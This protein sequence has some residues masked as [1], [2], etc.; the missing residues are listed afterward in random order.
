MKIITVIKTYSDLIKTTP[1]IHTFETYN[2]KNKPTDFE[3]GKD[4][5]PIDYRLVHIG[6]NYDTR[7]SESLRENPVINDSCMCLDVGWGSPAEQ[8]GHTM[9]AFEKVLYKENP[10]WIV[11]T[12]HDNSAL[13]CSLSAKKLNTKICRLEAGLRSKEKNSPDELNRQLTDR[14]GDLLFTQDKLSNENLKAEGI[15]PSDIKFVGNI[16]V[17]SLKL[18]FQRASRTNLPVTLRS[19]LMAAYTHI[20]DK[21]SSFLSSSGGFIDGFCLVS[22][23][24][25]E[26]IDKKD[27]L[28]SLVDFLTGEVSGDMPV[29]WPVHSI[30]QRMLQNFSL[31]EKLLTANNVIL[32]HPL[33]HHE[34]LRLIMSAIITITDSST[35]QEECTTLGTPCLA[36][37]K[38]TERPLTLREY[39]GTTVLTGNQTER[40]KKEYH[41]NRRLN[42]QPGRPDFWDGKTAMRCLDAILERETGL[43]QFSIN[44]K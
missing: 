30:T 37:K 29:I 20:S 17:D 42:Y 15:A 27:R 4:P 41:E 16:I 14:L 38:H 1:L 32:L 8:L 9:M 11:V 22:I 36:L 39:G 34:M 23:F 44:N 26:N 31:W 3:A 2:N 33:A 12:G 21:R 6:Q 40:I 43:F 10:D 5:L 25:G 7:I 24:Q 18:N 13:A 35:L 28:E 19:N